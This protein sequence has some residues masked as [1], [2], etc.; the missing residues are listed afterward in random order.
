M[1][2]A[3]RDFVG[4]RGAKDAASGLSGPADKDADPR[5]WTAPGQRLFIHSIGG[6]INRGGASLNTSRSLINMPYLPWDRDC[7]PTGCRSGRR[8]LGTA[9]S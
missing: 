8:V 9:R 2:L 4:R 1:T 5:E 6:G 7:H 3:Q